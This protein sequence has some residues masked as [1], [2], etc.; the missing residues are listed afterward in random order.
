MAMYF[1][2][3]VKA[4]H[5]G[6]TACGPSPCES[7]ERLC[8]GG[9]AQPDLVGRSQD[10]LAEW[11]KALAS[12]ASPQGRGFE[13]HSCQSGRQ[14]GRQAGSQSVSQ[15]D[16]FTPR[17]SSSR[18]RAYRGRV[19]P[20]ASLSAG[21]F[22]PRASL[23]RASL[24]AGEF[25]AGELVVAEFVAGELVAGELVAPHLWGRR[26]GCANQGW[27]SGSKFRTSRCKINLTNVFSEPAPLQC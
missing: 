19:C 20:R 15:S 14:A 13:P 26:K 11:S 12:G 5:Y 17:A 9:V 10:S 25:V 27:I 1:P 2:H 4:H 22:I 8:V 7:S 21:E 16:E 6:P 3:P 23:S 18:K 24:S